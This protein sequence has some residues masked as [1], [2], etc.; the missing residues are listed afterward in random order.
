[1]KKSSIQDSARLTFTVI[2]ALASIAAV[3]AR[4]VSAEP[5]DRSLMLPLVLLIVMLGNHSRRAKKPKLVQWT[6]DTE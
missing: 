2:A 4:F 6:Q 5:S 1:M 3:V